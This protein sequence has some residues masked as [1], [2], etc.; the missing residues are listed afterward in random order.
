MKD[1][2]IIS[3]GRHDQTT[4][5]F[6]EEYAAAAGVKVDYAPLP[7]WSEKAVIDTVKG[8]NASI[9]SVEPYTRDVLKALCP[10]LK[11]IIRFGVGYDNID[12]EAARG[13][14]IAVMI[15]GG[16]NSRA[17]AD[18]A[19]MLMLA[20]GRQICLYD[21]EMRQGG[22][23]KSRDCTVLE[24]KTVGIIGF[25]R[26]GRILSGYLSGFKCRL[27]VSDDYV[28]DAV[29]TSCGARRAGL[30]E[31]AGSSDFISLHIP[32][33]NGTRGMIDN[34]FLVKMKPTAFLINTSRG[35]VVNEQELVAALNRGVIAGAGLD[36]FETEPLGEDSPLRKM[37]NVILSPHTAFKTLESERLT[38]KI[39]IDN[40]KEFFESGECDDIVN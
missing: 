14:G 18:H 29:L 2:S 23:R 17:V 30:D 35:P 7:E 1:F 34:N 13:L 16:G 6:I 37:D 15:A 28:D 9:A 20:L 10:E 5:G 33:M 12:T 11:A 36:V 3:T 21:R 24:G 25:G 22:W 39:V 31:I 8:Y 4:R 26:I 27:L 19:I 40:L 38:S 32:L